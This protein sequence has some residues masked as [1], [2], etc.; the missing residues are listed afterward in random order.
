MII[1][2]GPICAPL[3]M[4]TRSSAAMAAPGPIETRS[5]MVIT[6]S[7]P[8]TRCDWSGVEE[9]RKS[10]PMVMAPKL[11]TNGAPSTRAP[12][13]S[14][15]T[16]RS[17]SRAVRSRSE[18]VARWRSRWTREPS[19]CSSIGHLLLDHLLEGGLHARPRAQHARAHAARH[20]ARREHALD[21]AP[22]HHHRARA[23]ARAGH[24]PHPA[25]QPHVIADD[26]GLRPLG[27][28]GLVAVIVHDDVRPEAHV[29]ADG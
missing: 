12:R 22:R 9:R 26:D 1:V 15:S 29:I 21:H 14:Q 18:I 25:R 5:P 8:V 27:L 10:S 11:S 3:P 4:I 6:P 13:P 19:T 2:Y 16:P 28:P 20:H 7:R 17:R 23:D 24:H